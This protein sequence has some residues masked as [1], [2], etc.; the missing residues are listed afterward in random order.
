MH[1]VG[2]AVLVLFTLGLWSRLTSVLALIVILSDVHRGAMLTSQFEPVLTMVMCYLCLGPSGASWSLDRL[3]ARRKATTQLARSAIEN[4]QPSWSA[5]VSIRLI[6]VHLAMLLATM[7]MAKLFGAT[8]WQGMAVWWLVARPESRLVDLTWLG[9][10]AV[11]FWTHA[12]L[13]VELAFP[14]L[15]WVPLL[16]PLMLALAALVWVSLALITGQVPFAAGDAGRQ[17]QLLVAGVAARLLPQN[18]RQFNGR[19]GHLSRQPKPP[20]AIRRSCRRR[21]VANDQWANENAATR[22]FLPPSDKDPPSDDTFFARTRFCKRL[23]VGHRGHGGLAARF[24]ARA[25][26]D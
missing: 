18:A 4:L 3:L 22:G 20:L 13:G 6:Q 12:I 8:W 17:P 21:F 16:R 14:I 9:E 15:V 10:Y 11:N 23:V 24:Q 19:R 5:T 25:V 1:F 26:G 2:L 7:G